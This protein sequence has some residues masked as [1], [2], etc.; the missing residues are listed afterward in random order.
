MQAALQRMSSDDPAQADPVA[1]T[2][3]ESAA[4]PCS[5]P[6][7]PADKEVD[8]H[9]GGTY[10]ST[11]PPLQQR[12]PSSRFQSIHEV[13]SAVTPSGG[14]EAR[15]GPGT[16]PFAL[17]FEMAAAP[18]TGTAGNPDKHQQSKRP[19]KRSGKS[20]LSSFPGSVKGRTASEDRRQGAADVQSSMV[21]A[22]GACMGPGPARCAAARAASSSPTG[23]LPI[24]GALEECQGDGP[25]WRPA[26]VS[27][28][29]WPRTEALPSVSPTGHKRAERPSAA[30]AAVGRP[31]AYQ[32][33]PSSARAAND[34]TSAHSGGLNLAERSFWQL[35]APEGP[36][37]ARFVPVQAHTLSAVRR[38]ACPGSLL[39]AH[40]DPGPLPQHAPEVA[41]T[42]PRDCLEPGQPSSSGSEAE[43]RALRA[44]ADELGSAAAHAT[45]LGLAAAHSAQ[46]VRSRM[47][48]KTDSSLQC[49]LCDSCCTEWFELSS[50]Q[51]QSSQV[52]P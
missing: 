25:A 28:P 9:V 3:A 26:G 5:W 50:L 6:V 38:A 47:F 35:G 39:A 34:S 8:V 33:T 52:D 14:H 45:S 1:L 20:A 36:L 16:E 4:Q 7:A 23:A 27:S 41:P 11:G 42:V 48:F 13:A 2:G 19:T 31:L 29:P 24:R 51:H 12:V 44:V 37:Q 30:N 18:G 40:H 17:D 49:R 10:S 46:M 21:G 22:R 43:R 15:E 32:N